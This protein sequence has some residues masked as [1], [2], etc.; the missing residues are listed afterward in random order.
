MLSENWSES[1]SNEI[2]LTD[3][4]YDVYYAFLY[5][6]Y[7]DCLDIRPENAMH[8]YDLANS[9][10]EKELK[11]KCVDIT[12]EGLTVESVCDHYLSAFKYEI[13]SLKKSCFEFAVN[14]YMD[15]SITDSFQKLDKS[16]K[17]ELKTEAKKRIT[18]KIK[19]K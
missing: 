10:L 9:Y 14:N 4:S 13:K 3:Y 12:A 2:S 11:Q 8:L 1:E 16:I 15:I 5:Y 19:L 7:T 6:I 17:E 18:K